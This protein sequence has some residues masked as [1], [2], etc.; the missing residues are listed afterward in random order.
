MGLLRQAMTV[1]ELCVGVRFTLLVSRQI[2]RMYDDMHNH[3]VCE[4]TGGG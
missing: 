1:S 3:A 2:L 4:I